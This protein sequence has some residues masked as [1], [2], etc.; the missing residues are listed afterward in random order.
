MQASQAFDPVGR[1]V[2]NRAEL[3]GGTLYV[4]ASGTYAPQVCALPDSELLLSTGCSESSF[5][6]YIR[7]LIHIRAWARL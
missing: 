4:T 2:V 5:E 6:T 1:T 3:A 7:V